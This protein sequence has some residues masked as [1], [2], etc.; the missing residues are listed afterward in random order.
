MDEFENTLLPSL[1]GV[2][3]VLILLHSAIM[4]QYMATQ[5]SLLSSIHCLSPRNLP[6][7]HAA[8][9]NFVHLRVCHPACKLD[10]LP[11]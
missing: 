1:V 9:L 7:K 6:C 5:R 11:C 8:S 4:L 3:A 2:Y 10:Y